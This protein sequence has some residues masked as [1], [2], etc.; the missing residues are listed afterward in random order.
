MPILMS[1]S[2][3]GT[4]DEHSVSCETWGVLNEGDIYREWA[5]PAAWRRAVA[6]CWEQRVVAG[7]VQRVVPDGRADLLIHPSGATEVVGV[8]DEVALAELPAG[9]W[10]RG[11][12]IRSEAVGAAFGIPASEFTNLTVAGEDLFGARSAHRLAD[13]AAR[14]R[15]LASVEPAPRTAVALRLLGSCSV[16]ATADQ[17]G[18]TIR[19][20]RRVVGADAGLSPKRYQRVVRFQRFIAAAERGRRLAAAAAEAGYADQAH[21]GRDVRALAGTTPARLLAERLG[22]RAACLR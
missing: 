13:P 4:S 7:R 21:L 6:C 11:I 1:I 12:R 15:W 17:L 9:T 22:D 16:E 8:A 14:H 3:W 19:Q 20:L 5:P 2:L 10:I 18:I